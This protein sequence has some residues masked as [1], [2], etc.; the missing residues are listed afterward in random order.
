M[1]VKYKKLSLP[2]F[3][4]YLNYVNQKKNYELETEF[5]IQWQP[6]QRAASNL[7]LMFNS[8]I[9]EAPQPP[10]ILEA[11]SSFHETAQKDYTIW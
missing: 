9:L 3:S 6:E 11:I 4:L 2:V 1:Y 10:M 7:K 8:S 5:H